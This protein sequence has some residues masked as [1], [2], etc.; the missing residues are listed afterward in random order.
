[1]T[2]PEPDPRHG[3]RIF[4]AARRRA[5]TKRC[6][7]HRRRREQ[8]DD[9]RTRRTGGESLS[10]SISS[11]TLHH[12]GVALA[13]RP[14]AGRSE[15][16]SC[17]GDTDGIGL[18]F[19]QTQNVCDRDIALNDIY[20]RKPCGITSDCPEQPMRLHLDEIGRMDISSLARL[21]RIVPRFGMGIVWRPPNWKSDRYA[22]LRQERKR[23]ER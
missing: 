4:H 19:S 5:Y 13:F 7:L 3:R 2:S 21:R 20:N 8:Q 1:M 14:H 10:R 15:P 22:R 18:V 11:E 9:R 12:E 17:D 6:I 16:H 23:D